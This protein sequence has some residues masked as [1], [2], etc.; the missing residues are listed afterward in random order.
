[1]NIVRQALNFILNMDLRAWRAVAV[2]VLLFGGVGLILTLAAALMGD[3]GGAMVEHLL[4]L[5]AHSP[6]A[7]PLA[8]VAFAALAFLGVPQFVL[9]AAAVAGFGPLLGAA[10]SWIG[11]LASALVGFG[12]GRR[13]GARAF[14]DLPG[15]GVQRFMQTVQS[16][17]FVASLVIRLVPSAPFIVVNMAAGAAGVGWRVFTAGTAIGIVPKIALVALAGAGVGHAARGSGTQALILAGLGALIWIAAVVVAR[18]R[19]WDVKN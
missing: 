9:I 2:T 1:M 6:F 5:A 17:G 18:R 14:A 16:N 3:R 8:V 7:L 19:A 10:Y 11:T 15:S 12:L 13:F 4:G